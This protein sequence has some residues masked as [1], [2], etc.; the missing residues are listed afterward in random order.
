MLILQHKLI[1]VV[2]VAPM[3]VSEFLKL[4]FEVKN[5][6]RLTESIFR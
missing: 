6:E 4:E 3:F 2:K 5:R 1:E